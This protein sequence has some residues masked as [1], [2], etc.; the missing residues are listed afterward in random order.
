MKKYIDF[1]SDT[2]TRPTDEMRRAMYEAPVGDDVFG[3]DPTVNELEKL[4]AEMTGKEASIFVPSGTFGNQLAFI[5]HCKRGDE[6]IISDYAH[7]VLYEAGGAAVLAG[8]QTRTIRNPHREWISRDEVEPLIRKSID[9]HFPRTGLIEIQNSLGNGSVM[10]L[11]EMKKIKSLAEEY[12]IPVHLDGARL[13]NAAEALKTSASELVKNT[14]SVM[15]CLS[16]GLCAPVGSMLAGTKDFI[17]KARFNRKMMGGGMRQVGILAAAGLVA[18]KKMT[19][20]IHE[21]HA[22]AKE[23]ARIFSKYSIFKIR[24]EDVETNIFYLMFNSE[25]PETAE[26]FIR[27]MTQKNILMTP[28]RYGACRFV[29]HNEICDDDLRYL[30]QIL[31]EIVEKM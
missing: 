15:F 8:V 2:I 5:T 24:E 11:Q 19:L 6:L 26:N 10:P 7:P 18:L 23:L 17:E 22:R 20:R 9:I 25:K 30:E 31:P 27:E 13:F 1:R 16:K 28:P 14:D 4:A 12:G 29:T 21:D 3:E